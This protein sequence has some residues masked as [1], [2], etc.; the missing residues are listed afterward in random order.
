MS[1]SGHANGW[2]LCYG[3]PHNTSLYNGWEHVTFLITQT[4]SPRYA[5]DLGQHDS[6]HVRNQTAIT[7][8]GYRT[9][10][11]GTGGHMTVGKNAEKH[12]V[13]IYMHNCL[14]ERLNEPATASRSPESARPNANTATPHTGSSVRTHERDTWL[15]KGQEILMLKTTEQHVANCTKSESKKRRRRRRSRSRRKAVSR[16]SLSA[17]PLV[18]AQFSLH[19]SFV[20]NKGSLEQFLLSVLQFSPFT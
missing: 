6:L 15:V 16:R 2:P 13:V 11:G 9:I 5:M 20:V 4:R 7:L 12:V 18:W 10:R 19:M 17:E 8:I 14:L 3:P 1:G